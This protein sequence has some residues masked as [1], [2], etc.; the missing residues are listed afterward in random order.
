MNAA[1][2]GPNDMRILALRPDIIL[3]N[4][5]VKCDMAIG[6]CACGAWHTAAENRPSDVPDAIAPLAN[7][8]N[9]VIENASELWFEGRDGNENS[10][11]HVIDEEGKHFVYTNVHM[12]SAPAGFDSTSEDGTITVPITMTFEGEEIPPPPK[13]S[14]FDIALGKK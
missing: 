3:H 2:H 5:G 1:P 12:T 4:G 9:D 14:R 10:D 6:P 8:P 11:M 13:P 7:V